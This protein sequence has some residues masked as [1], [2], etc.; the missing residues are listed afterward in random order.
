MIELARKA[1]EKSNT[2]IYHILLRANNKL[3]L[4]EGDREYF[5]SLLKQYFRDGV[6]I[7]GY[8]IEQERVHIVLKENTK[9]ISEA[10]KPFCTSYARYFNRIHSIDGKLFDGR[11]KSEP[12]EDDETLAKVLGY[13]YRNDTE[14]FKKDKIINHEEIKKIK[15]EKAVHYLAMDDYASMSDGELADVIEF[16][17]SQIEG[18]EKLSDKD[19]LTAV[20]ERDTASRLRTGIIKHVLGIDNVKPEKKSAP[21]H[22]RRPA[23]NK[24]AAVKPDVEKHESDVDMPKPDKPEKT[25]KTNNRKADK[26]EL[27]IWLL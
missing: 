8:R 20:T 15:P 16:L 13:L 19:K 18:F 1:R 5:V 14:S 2:G 21:T 6:S 4:N 22:T 24:R 26:K 17:C 27:P 25:E 12:I 7:Y 23:V 9:T 10:L 3:F 11:F